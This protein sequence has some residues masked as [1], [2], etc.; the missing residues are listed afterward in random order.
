M[1]LRIQYRN[2]NYDYVS[3]ATLDRLIASNS[4]KKFLRPSQDEWVDVDRGPIRGRGGDYAG[5]DR[6]QAESFL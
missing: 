2:Y 5:P 6:R 4:I 3:A 1:V